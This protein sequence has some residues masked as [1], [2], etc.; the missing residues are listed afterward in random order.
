M[1]G[2]KI[3]WFQRECDLTGQE[4]SQEVTQRECFGTN[5]FSILF[6]DFLNPTFHL[7]LIRDGGCI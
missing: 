4:D 7:K 6:L 5:I 1:R 3:S 2:K